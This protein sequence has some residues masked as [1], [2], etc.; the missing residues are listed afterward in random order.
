[1]GNIIK[2]STPIT[3]HQTFN[4]QHRTQNTQLTKFTDD[5]DVLPPESLLGQV[6]FKSHPQVTLVVVVSSRVE[7]SVAAL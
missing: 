4:T 3:Q 2:N 1:M 5:V 6:L 7:Q